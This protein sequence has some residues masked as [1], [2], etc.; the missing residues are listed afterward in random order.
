M[1]LLCDKYIYIYREGGLER[2]C[3]I[4]VC[5]VQHS[6]CVFVSLKLWR[7]IHPSSVNMT[8]LPCKIALRNT[9]RE[10]AQSNRRHIGLGLVTGYRSTVVV[11]IFDRLQH[12]KT[13]TT[14]ILFHHPHP[15]KCPC[16]PPTT[17]LFLPP[18]PSRRIV[19]HWK[20]NDQT[21]TRSGRSSSSFFF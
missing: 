17:T 9:L 21:N 18:P 10:K 4:G 6:V 20:I 13:N 15:T 5:M 1:S 7:F 16:V 8:L 12:D 19:W 2:D 11:W 3:S 14:T